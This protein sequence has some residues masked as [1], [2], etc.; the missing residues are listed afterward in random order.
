MLFCL[1]ASSRH[2]RRPLPI[3]CHVFT[4]F[5]PHRFVWVCEEE[6]K[7][8]L[9]TRGSRV[10][11]KHDKSG[12]TLK[13]PSVDSGFGDTYPPRGLFPCFHENGHV[14]IPPAVVSNFVT[15]QKLAELLD[16]VETHKHTHADAHGRD[17]EDN[18]TPVISQ[19]FSFSSLLSDFLRVPLIRPPPTPPPP[20]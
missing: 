4:L 5:R 2:K 12:L 10:I 14:S 8:I 1:S 16:A 9:T 13:N 17:C 3:R 18:D 7:R 6:P 15:L 19:G 20:T 11:V